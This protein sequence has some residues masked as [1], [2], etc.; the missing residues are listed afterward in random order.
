M[1]VFGFI[2]KQFIDVIEWPESGEGVLL[3]KYRA[4]DRE[5][6]NGGQ[7]T[8]RESQVALFVNEGQIADLF[9]PGLHTLNTQTL[10][11]LTALKNWDK[12]FNSPFKSDVYFMSTRVQL[13]QKWGTQQPVT[14]RDKDY[15]PLRI[16]T[17]GTFSYKIQDP[18]VFFKTVS[19]ARDL[20]TVEDLQGQLRSTIVSNM[21]AALGGA[22]VAFV[23]MSANQ[24]KMSEVLKTA[25]APAFT[26]L[27]LE[28][29]NF[30][31]ESVSL[32]EELQASLDQATS[33]NFVKDTRHFAQV[34]A[35]KSIPAAAES[36]GMMGAGMALGAGAAMGQTMG[37]LFGNQA[38]PSGNSPAPAGDDPMAMIEKIHELYKKG[39]LTQQEFEAK[40]AELLKKLG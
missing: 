8:V 17:F 2:K 24:M 20:Y 31:V 36:G 33:A 38:S 14:V 11:L 7:L 26:Q 23:D 6:Q 35:A 40:K 22:N 13:D 15:G 28:L 16:R 34:Q 1:S 3:S 39:I 4:E 12:L 19:G 10:P 25:L 18:K 32:P 9:P 30:Q 27:G 29:V 21:A 37:G 5:I